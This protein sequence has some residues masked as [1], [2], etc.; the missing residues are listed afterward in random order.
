[1]RICGDALR[2]DA[3]CRSD[4][5]FLL[6]KS[7]DVETLEQSNSPGLA[8]YEFQLSGYLEFLSRGDF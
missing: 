3:H 4:R 5:S 6:P 2:D 7:R 8:Q 1:L